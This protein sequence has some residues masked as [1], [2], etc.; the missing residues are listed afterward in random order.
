MINKKTVLY[1]LAVIVAVSTAIFY[2]MPN[3][4]GVMIPAKSSYAPTFK[5]WSIH[6]SEK[7]DPD[8]FTQENITVLNNNNKKVNVDFEWN[9]NH[10]V[11][12]LKAPETGYQV[13]HTYMITVSGAVETANG[14]QLNN[15]FT[16]SFTTVAELPG[17][18]NKEQLVTLLEERTKAQQKLF[19][20]QNRNVTMESSQSGTTKKSAQSGSAASSTNI[21]VKGVDE[22]DIVKTDGD[23]IYFSR[24]TDVVVTSAAKK[25]SKLVSTI[26]PENFH[27]TELYLHQNLLI[28]IGNSHKVSHKPSTQSAV[29]DRAVIPRGKTTALIYDV[30]DPK[31]PEKVREVSMDGSLISSRKTDGYLYLIANQHPP[32]HVLQKKKEK[33]DDFRPSIKDTAVSKKAYP[34]SYESMY[35]FPDTQDKSFLLLGSINLNKL[36]EKATIEA[37]LGASS[38]LYMSKNHLYIAAYQYSKNFSPKNN[39]PELSIARPPVNT[40]ISQFQINNGAI[41]YNASTVVEGRLINQFAMD[42]RDG[43]FRV[44]TTKDTVWNDDKPSTNNLYTFDMQMNP[45]GSLEGLAKGERIYS[46][47]FMDRFAYM[48]T[49][50]QVDPLFV[51]D[52]KNPKK[53]AV[54][55]KLKIPGFSNY[56]HP[57]DDDHLIGFGQ[58][59]KLVNSDHGQEPRVQIDGLKIS[60]FNVS[61]P[62]K[63]KEEYSEIIG[64]GHSNTELNHNHHALYKHPEKPI[65]GFP[66]TIYDAKTVHK[67]DAS[68]QDE[69][70]AFEGVFLYRITPDEGIELK[71]TIT[72]QENANPDHPSK[73]AHEIKRMIS[74]GNKLY[75]F[76]QNEMSV[77]DLTEENV[78]QTVQ[79]PEK[80]RQ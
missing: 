37:Y 43:T 23:F 77:Y 45:L 9:K 60:V 27:P 3:S 75:A 18:K 29:V 6:F 25:D 53:P 58:N 1:C 2:L 36:D 5:D 28:I 40:A 70:F 50:K 15:T 22:G 13:D 79:L 59:T 33:D 64:E 10:T 41:T 7:M 52:L 46:V 24:G 57:L 72:L 44:A 54:L 61:N 78:I 16:H 32:A 21:Q 80:Q 14:D 74:V 11:L 69:S 63:P 30:T 48:V 42:E 12:T 65:F 71:D 73:L 31:Q 76:S 26:S 35:F 49:F 68:Y 62:A 19:D 38:Q 55:G 17:I 67:G 8:T 47:R 34:L 66:A 56:L 4:I 39:G 20:T 51:I